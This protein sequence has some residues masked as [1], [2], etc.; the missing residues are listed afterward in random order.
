MCFHMKQYEECV[1]NTD[2]VS[3]NHWFNANLVEN[4]PC[5]FAMVM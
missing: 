2:D 5:L 4:V 1:R 3:I